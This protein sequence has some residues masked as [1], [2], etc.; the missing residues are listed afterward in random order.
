MALCVKDP[1]WSLLWLGFCPCPSNFHMP[2]LWPK[3][4]YKTKQE[5][6][7]ESTKKMELINT[8]IKIGE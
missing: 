5:N 8:F 6:C 1:A 3:K 4:E 2:Q 7:K